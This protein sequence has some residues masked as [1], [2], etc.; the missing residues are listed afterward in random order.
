[1][2][3]I[4]SFSQS[5]A[6]QYISDGNGRDLYIGYNNGGFVKSSPIPI[7]S[8]TLPEY[9]KKYYNTKYIPHKRYFY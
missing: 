3:H 8:V 6:V 5:K 7:G 1:M 9:H 2:K 4:N